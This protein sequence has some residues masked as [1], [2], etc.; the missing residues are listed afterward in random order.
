MGRGLGHCLYAERLNPKTT[1]ALAIT[2]ADQIFQG[3]TLA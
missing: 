2:A 1:L 3:R